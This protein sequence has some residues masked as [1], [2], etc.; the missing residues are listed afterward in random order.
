MDL[1]TTITALR[2]LTE[3][4]QSFVG[5][6]Q[7]LVGGLFGL[8]LILAVLR[9]YE[10]YNLRKIMKEMRIEISNLSKAIKKLK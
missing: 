9:W 1:N 10:A 5:V 3:S 6:V 8:Y 7:V 2:P 4:I